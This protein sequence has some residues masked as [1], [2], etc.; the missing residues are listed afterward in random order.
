MHGRM[1]RKTFIWI[2]LFIGSTA[3]GMLPALWG[4]DIGFSLSSVVLTAVG[5][6]IGIWAGFKA[7]DYLGAS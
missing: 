2:G 3:G 6:L 7:A 1:S 5:G 4:G